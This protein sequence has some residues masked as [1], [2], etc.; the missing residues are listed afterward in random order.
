M[1]KFLTALLASALLLSGCDEAPTAAAGNMAAKPDTL[2]VQSDADIR[3]D[4]DVLNPVINTAN[5]SA[6]GVRDELVKLGRNGDKAAINAAMTKSKAMFE[7]ANASLS[8]LALKSSEVQQLRLDIYQG[9]MLAIKLHELYLKPD[10]SAEDK[11]EMALLQRQS[12]VLQ[13]QAGDKLDA[14]NAK[15]TK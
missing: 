6:V 4:L 12:L 2:S 1:S 10:A 5:S 7:S 11:K 14:L 15:Y 13:K 9:N 3:T 8:A